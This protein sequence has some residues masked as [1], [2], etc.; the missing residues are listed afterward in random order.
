VRYLFALIPCFVLV[1]LFAYD[2]DMALRAPLCA[3]P[4]ELGG[5]CLPL[6]W[7]GP[8]SDHWA[9]RSRQNAIIAASLNLG[10]TITALGLSA[11]AAMRPS[12]SG[13]RITVIVLPQ[14]ILLLILA[15][16]SYVLNDPS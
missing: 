2:L 12:L 15:L 9:N 5:W 1:V 7:Q 4:S 11:F 6:G 10:A 3:S 16:K 8:F 13:N 14:I